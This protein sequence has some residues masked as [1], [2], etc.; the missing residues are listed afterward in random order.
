M[1]SKKRRRVRCRDVTRDPVS[2]GEHASHFDNA[3]V[4]HWDSDDG[5]EVTVGC[6]LELITSKEHRSRKS[7]EK[8]KHNVGREKSDADDDV[9]DSEEQLH[10]R[11]LLANSRGFT[12]LTFDAPVA[13][14]SE[15]R[16]CS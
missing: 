1:L 14:S 13:A 8:L 2:F 10:Y 15:A 6:L 11:H 9:L 4:R 16:Q 12:D 3:H 5:K 7:L